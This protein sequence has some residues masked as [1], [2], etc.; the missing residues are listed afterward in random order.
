LIVGI[1][2]LLALESE[3]TEAYG[4]LGL[5]ALGFFV[6]HVGG[7]RYGIHEPSATMLANSFD[8]V[9]RRIEERGRHTAPFAKAL[10]AGEIADGVSEALYSDC[11]DDTR[12]LDI[13]RSGLS[14]MV[15][16][17]HLLWAPDGDEAFDDGSYVLQFDVEDRVRLIAFRRVEGYRHDPTTLREIWIAESDFY[18]ILRQWHD[19]FEAEWAVR[20]KAPID[21]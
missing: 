13:S 5:R 18:D 12:F 20:P 19:E 2:S 8:E 14:R 11:M 6:I 1:P 3:I 9:G 15:H 10:N 21:D 17:N 4:N 7:M 16:S